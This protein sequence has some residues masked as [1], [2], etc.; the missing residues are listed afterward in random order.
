[1]VSPQNEHKQQPRYHQQTSGL[2]STRYSM[3]SEMA[4]HPVGPS[5]KGCAAARGFCSNRGTISMLRS[6]REG[7]KKR[8]FGNVEEK[9]LCSK[10][11]KV[12]A[13]SYCQGSKSPAALWRLNPLLCLSCWFFP[14]IKFPLAKDVRRCHQQKDTKPNTSAVS[15]DKVTQT[16]KVR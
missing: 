8:L 12:T 4:Q 9:W 16:H 6:Q 1:M 10:P 3:G 7:D 5:N 2:S 11:G 13:Y 15:C 14:L